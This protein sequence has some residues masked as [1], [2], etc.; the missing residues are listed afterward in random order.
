TDY[1]NKQKLTTAFGAPVPNDDN[2]KTTGPRG[3]L[4]TEDWWFLEK[5]A[6][7]DREVTPVRRMH[8]KGSGAYGTFTV[9]HDSTR[10]ST[11]KIFSEL[12]KKTD[13]FIRCSTDAG[14]RRAA[15]DERDIRGTAMKIYTEDCNWDLVGNNPPVFFM[16]DPKRYP[17][18]NHVVK[19]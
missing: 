3:T 8:A 13:M 12:G 17:D 6:H 7:F 11:A 15:D 10:Y 1:N 19:R 16:R 18:L 14:E 2:S 4:F 5:M 9:T